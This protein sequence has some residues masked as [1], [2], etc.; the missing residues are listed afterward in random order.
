MFQDKTSGVV[1]GGNNPKLH[2]S[3][4]TSITY[5]YGDG[6]LIEATSFAVL[7]WIRGGEEYIVPLENAMKW[8]ATRC[9]DGAFGSTQSVRNSLLPNTFCLQY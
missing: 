2:D 1:N 8:L 3:R 5:S 7:A 9:K 4:F 6:L